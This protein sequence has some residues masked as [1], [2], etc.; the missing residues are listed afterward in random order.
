MNSKKIMNFA[1]TDII[2]D[3]AVVPTDKPGL[4]NRNRSN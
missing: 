3:A 2:S 4:W 1:D